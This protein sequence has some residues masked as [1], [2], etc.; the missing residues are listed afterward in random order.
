M[1]RSMSSD[2]IV[3]ARFLHSPVTV[4]DMMIS[5]EKNGYTFLDAYKGFFFSKRRNIP[6]WT[7]PIIRR[8]FLWRNYDS[9]YLVPIGIM[10]YSLKVMRAWSSRKYLNLYPRLVRL[11]GDWLLV[12]IY[13][14]RK[15]LLTDCRWLVCYERKTLMADKPNEHPWCRS[16]FSLMYC[17]IWT[18]V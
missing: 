13:S 15:V 11:A 3:Q 8:C 4:E 18:L 1:W 2:S 14:E 16:R 7:K 5:F 6:F 9:L 10:N 17:S 12:L